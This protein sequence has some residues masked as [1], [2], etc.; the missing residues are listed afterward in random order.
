LILHP[1]SSSSC[2]IRSPAARASR[3]IFWFEGKNLGDEPFDPAGLR[4]FAQSLLQAAANTA[5]RHQ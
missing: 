4:E 1:S 3:I 5:T 2:S